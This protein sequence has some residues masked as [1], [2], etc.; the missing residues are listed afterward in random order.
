LTALDVSV[1]LTWL[2]SWFIG[3]VAFFLLVLAVH[4]VGQRN[5]LRRAGATR[6]A[7][8]AWKKVGATL[9][10]LSGGVSQPP[11]LAGAS[12][13][14]EWNQRWGRS[15]AAM[16]TVLRH[17]RFV[18]RSA[19]LIETVSPQPLPNGPTSRVWFTPRSWNGLKPYRYSSVRGMLHDLEPSGDDDARESDL[20]AVIVIT[21]RA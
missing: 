21:S 6:P 8:I 2:F 18:T 3:C 14:L 15:G 10:F 16:G 20:S 1:A 13:W 4:I 7:L 12:L 17:L 5:R 11:D 9:R 19:L